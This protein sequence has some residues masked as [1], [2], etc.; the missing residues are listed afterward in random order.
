MLR[1]AVFSGGTKV[2]E[3]GRKHTSGAR[4][5]LDSSKQR[6]LERVTGELSRRVLHQGEGVVSDA[7]R[8]EG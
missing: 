8:F 2:A 7:I 4:A 5:S 6:H 3:T 1:N